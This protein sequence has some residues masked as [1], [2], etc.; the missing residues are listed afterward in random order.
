MIS[1]QISTGEAPQA[2]GPYS[3]GRKWGDLVF[4]SGQ[5]PLDP[6]TGRMVEGD[7]GA[8]AKQCMKNALSVLKKAGLKADNILKTTIFLRDM[9]DFAAVNKAYEDFFS[10][11]YPA[12][13]CVAVAGLPLDAAVEIEVIAGG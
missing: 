7:V 2:V 3:Q 13:S 8:K 11:S 1:E 5:I 6:V 12:R 9:Q 4:V 10:G